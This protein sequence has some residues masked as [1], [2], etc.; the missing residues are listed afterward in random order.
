MRCKIPRV[1]SYYR[2]FFGRICE[3]APNLLDNG[4]G[5]LPDR[6]HQ[7]ID[8]EASDDEKSCYP[9]IASLGLAGLATS[10][11]RL[12]GV[13][14]AVCEFIPPNGGIMMRYPVMAWSSSSKCSKSHRSQ[15]W[16]RLNAYL[17]HMGNASYP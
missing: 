7:L 13:I 11:G 3:C 8:L 6:Q 14:A 12:L 5:R 9:S 15:I 2:S 17:R 1:E 10:R 4:I 16:E